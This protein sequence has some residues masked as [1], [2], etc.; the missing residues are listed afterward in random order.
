M[1]ASQAA[2]SIKSLPPQLREG[3]PVGLLIDQAQHHEAFEGNGIG[4]EVS[5]LQEMKQFEHFAGTQR[6]DQTSGHGNAPCSWLHG[7]VGTARIVEFN[8]FGARAAQLSAR[9][10]GMSLV[11]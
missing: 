1:V 2:F 10:T 6:S 3:K 5:A 7:S 8:T 11:H 9:A 4:L